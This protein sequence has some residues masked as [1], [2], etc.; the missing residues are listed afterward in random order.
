LLTKRELPMAIEI[1]ELHIRV[2]LNTK[3]AGHAAKPGG[4]D[5][6]ARDALVAEC[7][8]QVLQVLQQKAER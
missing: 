6:D 4:G 1:K 2:A 3:P 8:A 5:D 7:V